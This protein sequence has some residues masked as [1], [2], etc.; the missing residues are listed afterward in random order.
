MT[1]L[2]AVKIKI[3]FKSNRE[4]LRLIRTIISMIIGSGFITLVALK[5]FNGDEVNFEYLWIGLCGA[6][7]VALII[8]IRLKVQR[9]VGTLYINESKTR[10]VVHGKEY[11]GQLTILLNADTSELRS[12]KHNIQ[13]IHR[14]LS[15]GNFIVLEGDTKA[16]TEFELILNKDQKKEL[17]GLQHA[18]LNVVERFANRPFT[19]ESPLQ[20]IYSIASP[21]Y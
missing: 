15:Y 21:F 8:S 11:S 5:A 3:I 18:G 17:V 6:A 19:H 10:L 1:N 16:L 9:A 12:A 2:I 20:I 13:E 4:T 7:I 14:I